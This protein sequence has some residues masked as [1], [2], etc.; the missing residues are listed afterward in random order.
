MTR[1]LLWAL[2]LFTTSP[3]A[4]QDLIAVRAGRLVDVD[5]GEV[6]SNQVIL[7]RGERVEAVQSGTVPIPRGAKVID[8]AEGIKRAVRAAVR[9]IEHGSLADDEALVLMKERGT[10]LVADIWNGD[11]I[12][13]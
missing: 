3:L 11:Y 7:I 5:R 9:S 4:A 8:G 13:R 12:P 2:A 1:R 6:R 10:W